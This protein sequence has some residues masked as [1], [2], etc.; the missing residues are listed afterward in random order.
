M[1]IHD[2]LNLM[3]DLDA[4][5][6]EHIKQFID[7]H[8]YKLEGRPPTAQER[9]EILREI[10]ITISNMPP[11]EENLGLQRLRELGFIPD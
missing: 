10:Q 5:Q 8:P 1:N 4:Q 9:D 6:L 7:E 11:P 2:L 3:A